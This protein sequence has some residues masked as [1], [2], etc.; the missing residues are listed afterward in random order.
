MAV[1]MCR[2]Q[3]RSIR[4]IAIKPATHFRF[5]LVVFVELSFPSKYFWHLLFNFNIP[6]S[7]GV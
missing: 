3:N 1:A 5:A 7:N 4:E 6:V 2:M